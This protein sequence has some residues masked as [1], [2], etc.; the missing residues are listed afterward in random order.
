MKIQTTITVYDT[1]EMDIELP[2]YCQFEDK[3]FKVVSDK[4]T[5]QVTARESYSNIC[6]TETWLYEKDIARATAI[7]AVQ[8]ADAYVNALNNITGTPKAVA[9]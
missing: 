5:I 6:S 4:K 7:T 2:Y 8:F 9:A 1:I 3:F